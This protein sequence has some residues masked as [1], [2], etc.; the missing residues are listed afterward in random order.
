MATRIH[1]LL[2]SLAKSR[3][4]QLSI[5]FIFQHLSNLLP[6]HAI[7]KNDE[8]IAFPHPVPSWREHILIIPKRK[9][10]KLTDIQF[11]DKDT[12]HMLASVMHA[13]QTINP[14]GF[15]LLVNGGD[16]QDVPQLHFHL[17]S[18]EDHTG[19]S[20]LTEKAYV[21]SLGKLIFNAG[22]IQVY[23]NMLPKREVDLL[24]V[25]LHLHISDIYAF[26]MD[27]K[28]LCDIW[29][30][31]LQTAIHLAQKKHLPGYTILVNSDD[32]KHTGMLV[33][34]LLSGDRVS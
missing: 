18:G 32:S 24:L 4:A 31:V 28:Q 20:T 6:I 25:P 34:H 14:G 27:N 9:I 3:F 10:Q 7:L 11:Q 33:F 19:E 30:Q 8:L 15:T 12:Q 13:A 2:F 21:S 1:R 17:I 22:E 5:G 29:L 26:H 16:Y 23:G